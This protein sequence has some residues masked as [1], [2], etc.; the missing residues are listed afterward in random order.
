M[1]HKFT[2]SSEKEAEIRE[3]YLTQQSRLTEL[4]EQLN[5]VTQEKKQLLSDLCHEKSLKKTIEDTQAKELLSIEAARKKLQQEIEQL[6]ERHASLE[7]QYDIQAASLK[8]EKKIAASL[9]D[10]L[11][12]RDTHSVLHA[13]DS[14]VSRDSSPTPSL[15]KISLSG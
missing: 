7:R 14:S 4:M 1:Q 10:R 13:D 12:E 5:S 11:Q 6:R 8:E 9:R 3:M 2:K 15:G